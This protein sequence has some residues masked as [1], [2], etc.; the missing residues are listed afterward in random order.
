MQ[1]IE[2]LEMTLAGRD[3]V[4]FQE[5]AQARGLTL[6]E[7]LSIL[8]MHET[9]VRYCKQPKPAA[10]VIKFGRRRVDHEE[11]LRNGNERI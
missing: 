9:T 10:A 7:L 3:L 1:R 5:A 8:V 11:H 2:N 4:R 6:E